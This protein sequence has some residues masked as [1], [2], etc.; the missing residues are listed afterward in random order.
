MKFLVDECCDV[1]LVLSLR[2]EG[3]DVF[4]V[5]ESMP[6]SSD[7]EVL[8]KAYL[9]E[10]ILITEDKDFGELVFRLKMPA[11]GVILLRFLISERHLKWPKLKHLIHVKSEELNGKFVVVDK[12]KARLLSLV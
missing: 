1:G 2:N 3:Y 8:Q 7:N 10:R 4:Y 11:Y 6:S 9:E 12:D 5:K